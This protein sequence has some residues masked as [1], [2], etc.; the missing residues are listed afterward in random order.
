[1]PGPSGMPRLSG[2]ATGAHVDA[3]GT[4]SREDT[5]TGV[6]VAGTSLRRKFTEHLL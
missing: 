5:E 4:S 1:V 3:P 2:P 6:G